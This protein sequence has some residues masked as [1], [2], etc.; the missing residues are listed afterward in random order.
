MPR[1]IAGGA[2]MVVVVMGD[3]AEQ[4]ATT[5]SRF[6]ERSSWSVQRVWQDFQYS[7]S[8]RAWPRQVLR[9]AKRRY[10]D[11]GGDQCRGRG[12]AA[13]NRL[14]TAT[15]H[16]QSNHMRGICRHGGSLWYMSWLLYM[17]A[18]WRTEQPFLQINSRRGGAGI[19]CVRTA[20][21][22]PQARSQSRGCGTNDWGVRAGGSVRCRGCCAG[23]SGGV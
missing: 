8:H 11:A 1:I 4:G 17:H 13:E 14:F 6:S 3:A 15:C 22:A 10:R 7:T 21:G 16:T 9:H 12:Y 23:A 20:P 19:R 5:R 2:H 18:S